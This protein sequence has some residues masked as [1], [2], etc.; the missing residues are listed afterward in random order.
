MPLANLSDLRSAIADFGTGRT[1]LAQSV[2]DNFITLAENDIEHGTYGDGGGAV[3]P[4]LRVRQM[5][6]R[7][8]LTLVG[9]YTNLPTDFL[10]MREVSWSS[11]GNKPPLKFMTPEAFDSTYSTSLAGPAKS[12]T[13]VGTQLRVGPGAGAGTDVLNLSYYGS[14]PALVDSGSNWLMTSYPN[15]YLYGS[16]RH[17]APYIGA[18]DFLPVWQSAFISSVWAIIRSQGT[19]SFSGTSMAQ[20]NVGIT[21]T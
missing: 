9:E 2:I 17:L 15:A 7:T 1:D 11:Q 8:T 14:I 10:Q 12:W 13:V 4:P 18:M 19:G 3:T 20:A 5:E 6:V 21:V 16:L